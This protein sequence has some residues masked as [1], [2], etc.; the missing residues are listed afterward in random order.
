MGH[1]LKTL[2]AI[3]AAVA[4]AATAALGPNI[5]AMDALE[6]VTLR[7]VYSHELYMRY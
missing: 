6:T 7:C 3:K 5:A 1:A 2:L 4:P